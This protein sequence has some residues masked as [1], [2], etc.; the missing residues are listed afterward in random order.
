MHHWRILYGHQTHFL[1]IRRKAK[2]STIQLIIHFSSLRTQVISRYPFSKVISPFKRRVSCIN[3]NILILFIA[4][5]ITY[6]SRQ[7]IKT[8]CPMDFTA[9]P[10]DTQKCNLEIE[11]FGH[12]FDEI[13]FVK[14]LSH[15]YSYTRIICDKLWMCFWVWTI[16]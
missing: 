8:Y 16:S 13:R 3:I 2:F 1:S 4:G 14:I 10:F 5:D 15:I 11:S 9:Y 7:L 6:S 12:T